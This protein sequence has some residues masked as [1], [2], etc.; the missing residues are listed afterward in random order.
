M[1]LPKLCLI[2]GPKEDITQKEK[3]Q[4][5]TLRMQWWL[6]HRQYQK[7]AFH[8]TNLVWYGFK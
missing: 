2:F 1:P 8:F 3:A 5:E 7:I 4:T 6:T